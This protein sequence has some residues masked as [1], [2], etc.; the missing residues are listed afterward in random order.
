MV[1]NATSKQ[2]E[3]EIIQAPILTV[4]YLKKRFGSCIKLTH[5][6]QWL[7]RSIV[8]ELRATYPELDFHSHFDRSSI[9]TDG[10]IL[11][12]ESLQKTGITYPI[13]IAEAKNQGT[14]DR[15]LEE[16]L[17]KQAKGNA[18]ERLGKNLIGLRTALMRESIFPF[19]CSGWPPGARWQLQC[20]RLAAVRPQNRAFLGD[21]LNPVHHSSPVIFG[22]ADAVA[23]WGK[24]G[25]LGVRGV[26][27][28][29]LL[30]RLSL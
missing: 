5:E 7:L 26:C 6:K 4:E 27:G 13:L 24:R 28:A 1:I 15:R 11:F 8:A 2:Q 29:L 30:R 16:G 20:Q 23:F 9:R 18:I 25:A 17:S 22:D 12:M 3:T 10:G 21:S 19:V 14:N